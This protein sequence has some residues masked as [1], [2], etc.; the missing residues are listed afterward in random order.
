MA[1]AHG[2]NTEA[3]DPE[4]KQ[5]KE[6]DKL[7]RKEISDLGVN[8]PF[9]LKG[10][11]L[12]ECLALAKSGATQL[13]IDNT[14]RKGTEPRHP[15]VVSNMAPPIAVPELPAQE[16]VK[17]QPTVSEPMISLS[18]VSDIVTKAVSDALA[19]AAKPAQVIHVHDALKKPTRVSGADVAED[20]W[21]PKTLRVF[22]PGGDGLVM[23]HFTIG[24]K[25]VELPRSQI[26]EFTRYQGGKRFGDAK[27]VTYKQK[28]DTNSKAEQELF[29]K[30]DRWGTFF[31]SDENSDMGEDERFHM[32]ASKHA[33]AIG[34]M[35]YEAVRGACVALHIPVGNLEQMRNALAVRY[36]KDELKA[37]SGA[38]G[39]A[40]LTERKAN[41][42]KTGNE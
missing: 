6:A 20:D 13:Q 19:K 18:E 35:G 14:Y 33:L 22:A 7:I 30:D 42:F 25:T 28:Y 5:Q 39:A 38:A 9:Y 24:G 29:R 3:M 41:L 8:A 27:N 11:K 40:N 36:A 12:K 4:K 10:D 34:S 32:V 31:W 15:Q 2:P 37:S 1:S 21:S 26:I 16:P 23:T 17:E